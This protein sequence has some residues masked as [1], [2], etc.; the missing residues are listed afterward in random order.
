MHLADAYAR[1]FDA[2]LEK[3]AAT[4]GVREIRNAVAAGNMGRANM[5]AKTPGVLN[6]N[7]TMG[8][9][10]K[11]LGGG[12]EGLA[13]LVAH[14]QHGVAVRKTFDP[15]AGGYSPELIARKEQLGSLPG[16]AQHFGAARTMHNT[17]VHFN[18]FVQGAKIRR[19]Q[20]TP[21]QQQATQRAMISTNR[22][23]R[24]Q[25]FHGR[26]IRDANMMM[27][28]SGEAKVV[29]YLPFK[30]DEVSPNREQRYPRQAAAKG[31]IPQHMRDAMILSNQGR[32]QFSGAPTHGFD[33]SVSS[34]NPGQFNRYMF[35]G[36]V[37]A[38]R[39]PKPKPG[40]TEMMT[41][42]PAPMGASAPPNAVGW[43]K[44]TQN[45]PALPASAPTSMM[46]APPATANMRP[47]ARPAILPPPGHATGMSEF[48]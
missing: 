47:P 30:P 7:N 15:N 35:T 3:Y 34:A 44:M 28:P 43:S 26:D 24:Q 48:L 20:M 31:H 36:D 17:P 42:T 41:P 18:E 38:P 13:T 11:N 2:A 8:S 23:L 9:Q 10:I 39:M 6:A 16:A 1:G 21:E 14:P 37:T 25:G 22:A 40:A 45:Q 29:D 4:R 33:P 27:T 19:G 12:S 32:D 5:L 46:M